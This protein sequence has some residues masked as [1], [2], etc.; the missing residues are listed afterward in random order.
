MI[1]FTNMFEEYTVYVGH[2]NPFDSIMM[3]KPIVTP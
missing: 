3:C 2:L 1:L